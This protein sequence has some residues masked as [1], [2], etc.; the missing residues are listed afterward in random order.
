MTYINYSAIIPVLIEAFKEQQ[1]R[2]D[3]LEAIL[4]KNGLVKP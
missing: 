2:I 4:K 3:Q 1:A